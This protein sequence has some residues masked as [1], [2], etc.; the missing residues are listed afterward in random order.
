MARRRL[1]RFADSNNDG[2]A[3][4]GE[5]NDV[6]KKNIVPSKSGRVVDIILDETHPKFSQYGGW[7]SIGTIFFEEL[8]SPSNS[9]EGIPQARPLFPQ[10]KCLPLV[11]EIVLLFQL[12]DKNIGKNDISKTFYYLNPVSIWGSPHHNANPNV[13]QYAN[14]KENSK[15]YQAVEAGSIPKTKKNEEGLNLNAPKN[16]G[17]EFIEKNNI[18][19][20]MPF[21]GDNILESR[22]GSS[23]RLGSTKKSKSLFRNNWSETGENG[24]PI[25]IL[26]NGQQPNSGIG[27]IPTVENINDDPSSIYMTSNQ[28]IPI[29]ASSTNYTGI[30]DSVTYPGSYNEP[31]IILN[32]DRLVLNSKRDSILLSSQKVINLAAIEDIGIASRKNITFEAE[33]INFGGTKSS[34]PVIAGETF[35]NDLRMVVK[36]LNSIA[37]QLI[38]LASAHPPLAEAAN[39]LKERTQDLID[40]IDGQIYTSKK[41]KVS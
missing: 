28:N 7:N 27:Y 9:K 16:S 30:S 20:I 4:F 23:I 40:G 26:R 33:N 14:R 5:L 11:N 13:Y 10:L 36:P 3:Q 2:V 24:D 25:L 37:T 21:S 35:I 39:L 22:F 18:K 38:N 34:Q 32:S 1:L 19:P 41:V 31:Q 17:G 6:F 8:D 15:D 12:P 29:S